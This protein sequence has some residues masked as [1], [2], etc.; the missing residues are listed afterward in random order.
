MNIFAD[1]RLAAKHVAENS[2]YVFINYD[3]IASYARVLQKIAPDSPVYDSEHHFLGDSNSTIAYTLIMDSINFG[4]GYFPQLKKPKGLSGYFTV[5]SG[6]KNFFITNGVPT[7]KDL[8]SFNLDQLK[9]I[10]GQKDNPQADELM[11]LFR[12]ALKD[13]G[14]LLQNEF[15]SSY[16]EL[17]ASADHSAEKLLIRLSKMPFFNDVHDYYGHKIP[18]YKRAQITASDLSLALNSDGLGYFYDLDKL[19][20][21]ADNLLP[22][23][24]RTDGILKYSKALSEKLDNKQALLSGSAEEIEIRAVSLHACEIIAKQLKITPRELDILLWNKGQDLKYRELARHR[25]KTYFY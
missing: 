4:S 1:I 8:Q 2:R 18:L 14:E 22:H 16:N 5:S 21:F 13:L 23:V 9:T 11:E 19:T 25:T 15:G 12:Q 10:F 20:I 6:L 17:I 3:K 7:A 24:L